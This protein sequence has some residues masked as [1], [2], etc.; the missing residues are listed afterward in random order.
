MC[1]YDFIVCSVILFC[2]L[3]ISLYDVV[4][5]SCDRVI[6]LRAPAILLRAIVVRCVLLLFCNVLLL[7]SCELWLFVF[8]LL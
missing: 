3:D 4:I 5:F 1:Y 8:V 2:A 7:L 6:M